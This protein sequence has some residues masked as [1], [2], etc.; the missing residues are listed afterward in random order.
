[1]LQEEGILSFP[2][3]LSSPPAVPIPPVCGIFVV[4]L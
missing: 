1:M 2:A 3:T 4:S